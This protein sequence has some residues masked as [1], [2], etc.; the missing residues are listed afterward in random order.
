MR[1]VLKVSA[2]KSKVMVLGW[3]EGLECEVCVNRIRLDVV[4]EFKYLGYVLDESGRDEAVLYEGGESEEGCG[5][6]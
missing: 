6:Y 5:C 3:E 4:S 1:R 2:G